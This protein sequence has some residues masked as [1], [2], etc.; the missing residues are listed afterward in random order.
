MTKKD[1]SAK[2][3]LK[4]NRVFA[5]MFNT[6]LFHEDV[7]QP[8]YLVEK[9]SELLN[10]AFRNSKHRD[11]LRQC[12]LKQYGETLL[13]LLGIENQANI[14][15]TMPLRNFIYD[16]LSYEAQ[17][18]DI[19]NDMEL[20]KKNGEKF[21]REEFLSHFPTDSKIIPMITLAVYWG[22]GP[23]SGPVS[24]KELMDQEILDKFG[25]YI[26]DYRMNLVSISEL[27]D[28]QLS[29]FTT[30]LGDLMKMAKYRNDPKK[31]SEMAEQG[32]FNDRSEEFV[33]SVNVLTGTD[34]KKNVNE[35]GSV[36]MWQGIKDLITER[37]NVSKD[38]GKAEGKVE[39]KT[40]RDEEIV[41][42]ML[43]KGLNAE[44]IHNLTDI[45]LSRIK[46]ILTS[47]TL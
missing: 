42:T 8:E 1:F 39:G 37:E 26:A 14:D 40:E 23:W 33:E 32:F 46:S 6:V 30:E 22:E 3:I 36:D 41:K 17:L 34:F 12:S 15:L 4:D 44:T 16:A 7:I 25:V 29:L 35:R 11:I 38:E 47:I 13:L 45:S 21:S 28:E 43:K 19:S 27:E 9:D 18:R 31:L 20:R 2:L 5:D 10:K 24:I